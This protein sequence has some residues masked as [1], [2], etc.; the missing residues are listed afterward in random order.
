MPEEER[1]LPEV[2]SLCLGEEKGGVAGGKGC[3]KRRWPG[4]KPGNRSF[5]K[6]GEKPKE[7]EETIKQENI[8]SQDKPGFE[9]GFGEEVVK[10]LR[11]LQV[12]DEK[13]SR[14]P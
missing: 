7:R 4:K 11:P 1:A 2:P 5:Y 10:P 14:D 13:E 9:I 6:A 8:T 12:E 3:K